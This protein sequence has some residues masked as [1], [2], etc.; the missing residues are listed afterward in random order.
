MRRR[1][2]AVYYIISLPLWL[3]P[4]VCIYIRVYNFIKFSEMP[5]FSV[6]VP[7]EYMYHSKLFS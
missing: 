5:L 7:K 3:Y 6:E 4:T 2:R 1:R